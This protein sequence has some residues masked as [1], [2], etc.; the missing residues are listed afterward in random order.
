MAA[1]TLIEICPPNDYARS[2]SG[3]ADGARILR[4]PRN[5]ERMGV[6]PRVDNTD[7]EVPSFHNI[8]IS[9]I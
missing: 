8:R 9:Q 5:I 3:F 2:N 4:H 1:R 7:D 6:W